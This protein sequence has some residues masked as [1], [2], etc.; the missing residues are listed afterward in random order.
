MRTTE[1]VR[2]PVIA[3][4]CGHLEGTE[5]EHFFVLLSGRPQVR[6]LLGAPQKAPLFAAAGSFVVLKNFFIFPFFLFHSGFFSI[7]FKIGFKY[8]IF[9]VFHFFLFRCYFSFSPPFLGEKQTKRPIKCFLFSSVI[10]ILHRQSFQKY[11]YCVK[12]GV[13]W[14]YCHTES[15][16]KPKFFWLVLIKER[17]KLCKY[18]TAKSL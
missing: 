12:R 13:Y 15:S 5:G 4:I 9:H 1:I 11:E 7:L 8:F 3:S 17:K 2:N 14:A 6:I 10:A 16:A 18:D